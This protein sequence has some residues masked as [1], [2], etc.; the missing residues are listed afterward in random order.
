MM[1]TYLGSKWLL[2][3][4][5]HVSNGFFKQGPQITFSFFLYEVQ[6]FRRQ[7]CKFQQI[8]LFV[9]KITDDRSEQVLIFLLKWKKMNLVC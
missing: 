2:P 5:N 8:S 6:S 9:I 3:G 1:G 4:S 7:L